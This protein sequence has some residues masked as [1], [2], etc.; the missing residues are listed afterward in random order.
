[1]KYKALKAD[2]YTEAGEQNFDNWKNSAA[3]KET[4]HRHVSTQWVSLSRIAHTLGEFI[5]TYCATYEEFSSLASFTRRGVCKDS[6]AHR[7]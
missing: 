7:A 6:E 5:A 4:L 2:Y 3:Y 1:M